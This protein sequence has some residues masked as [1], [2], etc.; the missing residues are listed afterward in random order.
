[1]LSI[2]NCFSFIV[3]SQIDRLLWNLVLSFHSLIASLFRGD[4]ISSFIIVFKV[5]ATSSFYLFCSQLLLVLLAMSY[6]QDEPFSYCDWLP[7]LI[8]KYIFLRSYSFASN[9]SSDITGISLLLN[10]KS[11]WTYITL[12]MLI[13]IVLCFVDSVDM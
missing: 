11:S 7:S 13:F 5:Y 8:F 10:N 3:Y 1:M 12:N 4:N 2:M 6:K 9:T